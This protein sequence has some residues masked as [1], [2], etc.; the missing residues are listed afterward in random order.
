ML[1]ADPGQRLARVNRR[2]HLSGRHAVVRQHLGD[3]VAVGQLPGLVVAEREQAAVH[4]REHL[5]VVVADNN[6]SLQGQDAAVLVRLVPD[7]RLPLFDVGLPEGER[8]EADL[9]AGAGGQPGEDVFVR[10]AGERAAVVPGDSELKGHEPSKPP[11]PRRI[12]YRPSRKM[13]RAPAIRRRS[14]S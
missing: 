6:P 12:P 8:G 3:L 2:Q 5:G 13:L 11:D 4:G 9:P 10:V 1:G 7:V 14:L